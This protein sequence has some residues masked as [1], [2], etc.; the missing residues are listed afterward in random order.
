M[1]AFT[2]FSKQFFDTCRLRFASTGA[3]KFTSETRTGGPFVPFSASNI[4]RN[5]D[6]DVSSQR[7][8]VDQNADAPTA[9]HP[10]VNA[11]LIFTTLESS[12]SDFLPD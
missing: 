11:E 10:Q 6:F 4:Y 9:S 8:D 7:S 12:S 2:S 3:S 1:A 5:L